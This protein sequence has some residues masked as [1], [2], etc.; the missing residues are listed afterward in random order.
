MA[1]YVMTSART[2]GDIDTMSEFEG[3]WLSLEGA[4]ASIPE[5]PGW[6]AGDGP[7]GRFWHTPSFKEDDCTASFL[8]K[9]YEP[10]P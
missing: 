5:A 6:I 7:N 2:G 1:V 10:L 4:Q 9:E 3:V 8:I